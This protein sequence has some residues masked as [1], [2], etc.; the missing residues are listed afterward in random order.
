MNDEILGKYLRHH[1][2]GSEAALGLAR[3]M[4]RHDGG[5]GEYLARVVEELHEERAS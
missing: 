2:T 3:E 5:I 1:L 4:G